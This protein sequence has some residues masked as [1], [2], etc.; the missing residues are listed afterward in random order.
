MAP[1]GLWI[2]F[3]TIARKDIVRIFRIWS[4][5]FLPSVVTSILYFVVFGT[6]IGT[7]L[8][9]FNGFPYI[10]FIVPGLVML[11]VVTNSF[12]NVATNFFAAKFFVFPRIPFPVST[13][14]VL[15][16]RQGTTRDLNSTPGIFFDRSGLD[17]DPNAS[18]S[19]DP[20]DNGQSE[21]LPFAILNNIFD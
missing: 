6:I 8:G 5:T 2:A 20:A 11:A 3:Y 17:V 21:I 18:D 9:D 10:H 15:L 12:S 14:R 7:R 13:D 19:P 1:Y 16:H 4:Q